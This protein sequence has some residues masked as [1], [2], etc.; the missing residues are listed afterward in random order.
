MWYFCV[1]TIQ[2]L[3]YEE[4]YHVVFLCS[5]NTSSTVSGTLP[6]GIFLF[7]QYKFYRMRNL[8]MWYF[9]AVRG[10]SSGADTPGLTGPSSG[11]CIY[12]VSAPVPEVHPY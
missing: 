12:C 4:P 5:Y 1:H 2:V 3:L 11:P 7:L 8:T 10:T 6:C 9:R